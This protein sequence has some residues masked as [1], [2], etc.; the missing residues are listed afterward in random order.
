MQDVW[1]VYIIVCRY[2][3]QMPPVSSSQVSIEKCAPYMWN[4]QVPA[5]VHQTK[6]G[7]V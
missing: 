5:R 4:P 7:I 3:D 6:Q 2:I 1:K